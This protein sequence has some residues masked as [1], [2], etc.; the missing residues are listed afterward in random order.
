LTNC[1]KYPPIQILAG[2]YYDS[3]TGLHYNWHR[4]YDLKT[5][6]YLRSDPIGLAAGD[7][8]LYA[9]VWNRPTTSIDPS[10]E[11]AIIG[12]L[13]GVASDLAIQ[14]AINGGKLERVDW[15]QVGISGALGAVGGGWISGAFKHAKSGKSWLRLS[16]KFK[17]VSHRV[18]EAQNI[19]RGNQLHHWL[20]PKKSNVPS[21]IKNHPWNLKPIP[22]P[23]HKRIHGRDLQRGLPRYNAIQRWWYGTPDWAKAGEVSITSGGI[24]GISY[25]ECKC[26]N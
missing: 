1:K 16:Q 3:E 2:Q 8:N 19:P 18:K 22:R 9:Y 20:I 6:R 13:I 5:G 15:V 24:G 26:K 23:I 21:V 10:G 11:F 14:L 7:A 12:A 4:Y 17:N 25:D